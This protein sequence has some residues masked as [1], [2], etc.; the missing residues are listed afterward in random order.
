[1]FGVWTAA[2]PLIRSDLGLSYVEVGLLLA[3]P[4]IFASLLEPPLGLLGDAWDRRA[5]VRMGGLAFVGGLLLIAASDGF[6]PMLLALMLVFPASGAFVSLSQA[7]LMD[8]DPERH[9]LNMARWVL[10][11]SIGVVAGPIVLTAAGS[12]GLGWRATFAAIAGVGAIAV[13]LAWPLPMGRSGSANGGSVVRAL[14]EAGRDALRALRRRDVLRWL[15]LLNFSDLMLD[16]LHGFLALYFVDVMGATGARAAFA[17]VVYTGVGLVGDALMIPLLRRVD[18]V[19][20]LRVSAAAMLV[21][22][23][24]F[25]LLDDGMAKLALL[26]AVG[27]L[28]AGWYSILKGRLYS[29]M[30]GQSATVMALDSLSGVVGGLLPLSVGII[31]H[32]YG[33]DSAMWLLAAGPVALLAGVFSVRR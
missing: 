5:L 21:V 29:A 12:V 23:P 7:T 22:F 9:E 20:Y 1:V 24:V 6:V 30:P 2:W 8:T 11:G 18:G 3:V 19:R 10:A 33:L 32:R 27:M 25:L 31:A 26:A 15:A 28:N 17:I 14:G 13:V 16:V 4:H